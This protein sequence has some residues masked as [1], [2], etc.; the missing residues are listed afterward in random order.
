MSYYTHSFD[1]F[2]PFKKIIDVKLDSK[3]FS[4]PDYQI[5]C[6]GNT[7]HVTNNRKNNEVKFVD[8]TLCSLL[9][10]NTHMDYCLNECMKKVA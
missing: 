6:E 8:V 2:S 9:S 5:V 10:H 7:I 3:D 4:D 1:V